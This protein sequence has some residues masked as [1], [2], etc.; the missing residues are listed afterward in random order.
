M[1]GFAS[2][3]LFGQQSLS[4][5]KEDQEYHILSLH[6]HAYNL[7]LQG[8]DIFYYYL[9]AWLLYDHNAASL[10][11]ENSSLQ[12]F[13]AMIDARINCPRIANASLRTL[14]SAD[15][16]VTIRSTPTVIHTSLTGHTIY[17]IKTAMVD[18]MIL[19]VMSFLETG[20]D[21][22]MISH[23]LHCQ[24]TDFR[25]G[26]TIALSNRESRVIARVLSFALANVFP[27]AVMP[28]WQIRG[29]FRAMKTESPSDA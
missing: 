21:Q 11:H 27:D 17:K 13:I 19:V 28:K 1:P 12:F 7:G 29:A 25:P 8:P 3:Y 4:H 24:P 20:I 10:I 14:T 15:F 16:W 5:L 6:P 23:F 18:F 2:H 9:P 26:D 22:E